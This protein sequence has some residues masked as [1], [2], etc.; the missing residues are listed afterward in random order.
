MTPD[1]HNYAVSRD[2]T[3]F[4]AEC[5]HVIVEQPAQ[6]GHGDQFTGIPTIMNVRFIPQN[7]EDLETMYSVIEDCKAFYPF[8]SRIFEDDND[9]DEEDDDSDDDEAYNLVALHNRLAYQEAIQRR[10]SNVDGPS[11]SNVDGPSGTDLEYVTSGNGDQFS[12]LAAPCNHLDRLHNRDDTGAGP[13]GT[14][15]DNVSTRDDTYLLDDQYLVETSHREDA[16]D[17]PSGLHFENAIPR[18]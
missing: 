7:P 3:I 18:P 9:T 13:S 1:I 16:V 10:D 12:M 11:G 2:L 15:V 17:G 4:P 14:H 8:I 5:L 6:S